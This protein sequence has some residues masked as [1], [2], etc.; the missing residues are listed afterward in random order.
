MH[1]IAG[2]KAIRSDEWF[3]AQAVRLA[4]LFLSASVE[5]LF[6][7]QSCGKILWAD[8]AFFQRFVGDD[9]CGADEL[10]LIYPNGCEEISAGAPAPRRLAVEIR[11][12]NSADPQRAMAI[13]VQRR[14]PGLP[15]PILFGAIVKSERARE[16]AVEDRYRQLYETAAVGIYRSTADGRAVYANP[17][18]VAMMGYGSEAAWVEALSSIEREWYV[19]KNRRQDFLDA[20]A[21]TGQVVNFVSE[22]Y[23]HRTGERI[24]V[25]ES[26]RA[27]KNEFGEVE[28]FEGTIEDITPIKRAE[29]ELRRSAELADRANRMKTQFIANMSHELRTPLN[30]I[31]GAAQLLRDCNQDFTVQDYAGIIQKSAEG[32]LLI[33]NDLLDLS[34]I[35]AGAATLRAE[36]FCLREALSDVAE[37]WRAPMAAKGLALRLDLD[38]APKVFVSD[39][40]FLRQILFNLLSN[41]VKFTAE[42]EIGLQ[43]RRMAD[44]AV[45]IAVSDTGPGV[46]PGAEA[47]IFERFSQA[48]GSA[49]RAFGGVGLGL[50]L[51]REYAGLL[52]GAI[53]LENDP[54]RGATFALSLPNRVDPSCPAAP[55]PAP[56]CAAEGVAAPPPAAAPLRKALIVED[57]PVNQQVLSAMLKAF[58][59][60]ADIANDGIEGLEAIERGDY[61]IILMDIQMPRMDGEQAVQALRS[62]QD[63]KAELPVLAVTANAMSGD[64]ERF[65]ASG[66]DGYVPKP[67]KIAELLG[68]IRKL[69]G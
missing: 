63:H 52:G 21:E 60:T 38:A 25:S 40:R 47:H 14:R 30:G 50:A 67:I 11:A 20:I 59:L 22:I 17:T 28:Y 53:R 8:A 64:R 32:L 16:P 51:C 46:A 18:F 26:A 37:H 7:A 44:G 13:I 56:S 6:A 31:L 9:P 33:L 2:P 27:I 10:K 3:E 61:A 49:T 4:P 66:F 39:P 69:T 24:W 42:G 55:V 68:E 45:E 1:V 57:N 54:G 43:C 19:E 41:A 34:R 35:D 5:G 36:P 23:R 12:P 48:D 58:G 29:A 65:L 62:R 15:A